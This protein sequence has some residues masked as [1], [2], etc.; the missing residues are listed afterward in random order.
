MNR[1]SF[2]LAIVALATLAGLIYAAVGGN[3]LAIVALAVLVT[4]LLVATGAIIALATQRQANAKAQADFV[5]NARENMAIMAALQKTQ[6]LQNQSLL[7]QLGQVRRL[8][9][10]TNGAS[11]L[12]IDSDIFSQLED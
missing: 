8:P 3:V 4:V 2:S 12:T 10:T 7:S 6:N 11:S 1:Y 5:A 9:E